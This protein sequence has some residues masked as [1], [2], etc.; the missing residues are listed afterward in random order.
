MRSIKKAARKGRKTTA[1]RSIIIAGIFLVLALTGIYFLQMEIDV[2][3]IKEQIVAEASSLLKETVTVE[4]ATFRLVPSPHITLTGVRIERSRWG[5]FAA[6]EIRLNVRLLPLQLKKKLEV[7]KISVQG[8]VLNLIVRKESK[9]WGEDILRYIENDV[10]RVIPSLALTGGQ[11]NI[12]RPGG[13]VPLF[14]L[15][16]MNGRLATRK[17]GKLRMTLFLACPGA[18]KIEIRVAKGHEDKKRPA[19]SLSAVGTGITVEPLRKVILDLFGKDETVRTVFRII[20][21]GRLSRLAFEGQGKDFTEA[22]DFERV[23][24]VSGTFTNGKIVAP[25]ASL[26]LED[27]AGTFAIE[28]AVLHCSGVDLRLGKSIGSKGELAVGLIRKREAFH[29]DVILDAAAEDLVRYLPLVIKDNAL[30][31]ELKN[32]RNPRGRGKGRL[33]LGDSINNIFPTIDAKDFQLSFH[34]ADSPGLI[35]VEG[36]RLALKK[37]EGTWHADTVIWKKLHWT[38]AAGGI[39]LRNQGINITVAHADLCG[40]QCQGNMDSHAGIVTHAYRIGVEKGDLASAIRCMWGV[41]ASIEGQF[42]M[43]GDMWAEGREDPLREASQ[44]TVVFTSHNGR[45]QR[46]TLLSQLFGTLNI[47]GLLQGDHP[48]Y[49]KK[50]FHYDTFTIV[51]ELR[52]GNVYL[53]EAVIDAQSMKIV[54][55]GKIDLVKGEADMVVLL[56]P[57][58]TVDAI[59][60]HIPVLGKIFTGKNGLFVSVAFRVKGPL[61]NP[62][63]TPLPAET[64]GS[65]LW[66]MLKRIVQSPVDI[67]K[68]VVPNKS[69]R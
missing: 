9:V 5:D 48:E 22:L 4:R 63:I 31:R 46:W 43:E 58:K 8:A 21:D 13:K 64:V 40:L 29:L 59:M 14:T 18:E 32:F 39:T 69:S 17:Q 61:D 25:P 16:E 65:G 60:N 67:Y 6:G 36:G 53:K 68:S 62:T 47:I 51:G 37:D 7:Q 10:L 15:T 41:E 20:R 55:E 35:S 34:L 50:G 12:F 11:V 52:N 24:K 33:V 30:V 56:A 57:L 23:V 3:G 28:E 38:N 19:C 26:P 1:R 27:V 2:S 44:G 49:M 66:G 42:R 45:I 54:G